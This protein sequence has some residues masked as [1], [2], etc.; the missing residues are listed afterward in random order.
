MKAEY[1]R[2]HDCQ[3]MQ[4]LMLKKRRRVLLASFQVQV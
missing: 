2:Y 1:A 4:E 3:D